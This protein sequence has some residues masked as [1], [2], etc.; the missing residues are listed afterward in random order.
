MAASP[1]NLS[2]NHA[3]F[4]H[5]Q[6]GSLYNTPQHTAGEVCKLET[7]SGGNRIGC[8]ATDLD[9]L[10]G[11]RISPILFNQEMPHRKV[12][13]QGIADTGSSSLENRA[14]VPHTVGATDRFPPSP[15]SKSS[16]LDRPIWWAPPFD[17]SKAAPAWKL[18]EVDSLQ[19]EFQRKLLSCWPPN[20][21]KEQMSPIRV[22]GNNGMAGILNGRQILFR[23]LW[24][25]F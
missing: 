20:G 24:N 1:I 3:S 11:F 2:A 16:T 13:G 23:A 25:I 8:T 17:G 15:T 7:R 21:A 4:W 6:C 19:K 22:P 14:M 12:R 9:Q 18:S 5:V 10:V